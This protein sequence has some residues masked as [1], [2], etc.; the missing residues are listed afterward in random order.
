MY[1][2]KYTK[3]GVWCSWILYFTLAYKFTPSHRIL[4][5][6]MGCERSRSESMKPCTI[7][8]CRF[9]LHMNSNKSKWFNSQ[10]PPYVLINVLWMIHNWCIVLS[11]ITLSAVISMYRYLSFPCLCTKFHPF[12]LKNQVINFCLEKNT[13]FS[14]LLP[15]H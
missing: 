2:Y 14:W 8:K 3:L 5:K 10:Y 7:K 11:S 12:T 6:T 13:V 15:L 4:C 1:V 9:L